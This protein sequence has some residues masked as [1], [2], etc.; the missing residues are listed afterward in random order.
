IVR[1]HRIGED[2]MP[3][4]LQHA[5]RLAQNPFAVA[6]V[7][8]RV[9]RPYDIEALI[10][11]GYRLERSVRDAYEPVETLLSGKRPV[12]LVLRLADIEAA[13]RPA[14][15]LCEIARAAAIAGADVEY[16]R[17]A[18][19]TVLQT[20]GKRLDRLAARLLDI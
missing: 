18:F 9:L 13:H 10:G 20:R 12:L 17:L 8:D 6:A 5:E 3:A 11:F 7:Q 15:G 19:E 4:G 16:R 2:Q 14:I 1:L